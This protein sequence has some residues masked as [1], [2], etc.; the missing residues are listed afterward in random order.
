MDKGILPL[1]VTAMIDF[2]GFGI[3][4]PIAPFYT[5][6][7]GATPFEFSILL[8]V[9]SLAQFIASPYLGRL[10]DRIGRKNVLVLGLSGEIAGYLIFGLSPVLSLL[11]IGRAI[12][13][14]T[15]GNLPVIYSFVS[16]KT[17]SDNRTRA[18]GMIGAAIG[19]GFVIGPFIGGSLSIFGYRVPI[20]FAAVLSFINMVLVLRIKEER[21][22]T[23]YKKG[24]ILKAFEI[25]PYIFIS[26][27][28]IALG[29]VML[30]TTLAYYGQALYSWGSLAVGIIL[31][32]VGMEQA[33]FQLLLVFRLT[34]RIGSIRTVMLGII[35]FTMAFLILSFRVN[36]YI[37][38]FS[39]TLFSLGYSLFQTPVISIISDIAP[40]EIRGS[41]LGITQSAQSLSNIIGPLI[42][43]YTFEFISIYSPYMLAAAFG[44]LSLLFISIFIIK[45]GSA[46]KDIG[47]T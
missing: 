32:I 12:T 23:N 46:L 44:I 47:Y 42:A 27:T 14:A 41:T 5:R 2:I 4:I 24:S 3:I 36:E 22:K 21:K 16:D 40:V 25:A 18:I 10:S 33:L 28:F 20:L 19:I 15:S 30:Q 1:F 26:I 13:G 8:V 38:I 35:S 9:Y 17:S 31:G 45:S 6:D 37:A 7:L 43:G 11:Y 29:F 39:L 34:R